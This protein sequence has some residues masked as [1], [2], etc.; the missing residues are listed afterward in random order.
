M[1]EKHRQSKRIQMSEI[2][3]QTYLYKQLKFQHDRLNALPSEM[4]TVVFKVSTS[5][6]ADSGK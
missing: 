1:C 4:E 2:N 3:I 6:L 5:Q